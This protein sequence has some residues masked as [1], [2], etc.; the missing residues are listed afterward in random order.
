[1]V[2]SALILLLSL[3]I[4]R[5]IGDPH[6]SYH[7]IALLGRII[8]WWEIHRYIRNQSSPDFVDELDERIWNLRLKYL[9]QRLIEHGI[10]TP[11]LMRQ[12][13]GMKRR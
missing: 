1:M 11:A 4:D 13:L 3:L 2:L 5:V 6:S 8:T 7:P 9:R 12:I 10:L